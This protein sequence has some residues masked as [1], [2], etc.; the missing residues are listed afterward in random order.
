MAYKVDIGKRIRARRLEL[1]MSQT[2]LSSRVGY[3]SRSSL[4][5]IEIGKN[6]VPA[7]TIA[8]F[9][10]ELKTTTAYLLGSL[11]ETLH[12]MGVEV[13]VHAGGGTI[14]RDVVTDARLAFSAKVWRQLEEEDAFTAVWDAL[15][16]A[17]KGVEPEVITDLDTIKKEPTPVTES[18]LPEIQQLFDQLSPANQSKLLELCRLYLASQNKS[19]E[20][21]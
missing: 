11:E 1:N 18:E 3:A 21:E 9:A 7:E 12:T 2:E 5:K 13:T 17:P 10:R 16:V 8:V 14:L 15:T 6:A 4:N 19:E 20:T